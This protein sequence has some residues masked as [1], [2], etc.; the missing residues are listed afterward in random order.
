MPVHLIFPDFITLMVFGE[1]EYEMWSSSL[2]NFLNPPV[3]YSLLG[4]L[5]WGTKFHIHIKQEVML[6]FYVF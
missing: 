6:Q 3:T 1:E 5:M 2:C 4:L